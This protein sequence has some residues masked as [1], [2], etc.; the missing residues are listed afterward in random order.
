[1]KKI[2]IFSIMAVEG[3]VTVAQTQQ[4]NTTLQPAG[5]LGRRDY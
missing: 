2:S 1:M 4:H 5:P 3:D